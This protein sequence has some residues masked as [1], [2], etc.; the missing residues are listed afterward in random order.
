MRRVVITGL[1]ALTPFGMGVDISWNSLI[2]GKSGI[3]CMPAT[4]SAAPHNPKIS[5]I[6]SSRKPRIM[7]NSIPSK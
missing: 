6:S 3:K 4:P 7:R 2:A 5:G 1:G